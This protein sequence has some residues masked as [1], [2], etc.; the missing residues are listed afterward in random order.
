LN[1]LPHRDLRLTIA[2]LSDQALVSLG[3]FL[4]QVIL[5]RYLSPQDY[6]VFA[7]IF[8]TLILLNVCHWALV[9][10]PLSVIGASSSE[11]RL[12]Q[13]TGS[14][15]LLT[16]LLALP[17]AAIITGVTLFLGRPQLVLWVVLA[18]LTWQLQE[19]LRRGLMAHLLH[20]TAFFGDAISYLG[21]GAIIWGLASHGGLT[22]PGA[23]AVVALT[24]A[25]AAAVQS[26]QLR[27]KFARFRETAALVTVYWRCGR[28]A[29]GAHVTDT[30]TVQAF[31]WALA[32]LHG[33]EQAA[34]FQ[35]AINVLG[36]T[37]P[38]LLGM[39]NLIVPS[40]ARTQDA[41]EVR[42]TWRAT[43]KYATL[44]FLAVAPCLLALLLWPKNVLAVFYGRSSV[45]LDLSGVVQLLALAYL[46]A[47]WFTVISA[48]FNGMKKA[49]FVFGSELFGLAVALL[50]GVALAQHQGVLGAGVGV[51]LVYSAR[52]IG[53]S[54][55]LSRLYRSGHRGRLDAMPASD[56][57]AVSPSSGHDQ[58]PIFDGTFVGEF[59][60]AQ[61]P[62]ERR[63]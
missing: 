40:S 61:K 43:K 24:S 41:G 22:L 52:L 36:I 33:P 14:S 12:R 45:Y 37:N 9:A 10:Y 29:L 39:M 3:G 23:F 44:G 8:G 49:S 47:Y 31:P 4:T 53:A 26:L 16:S 58:V 5:A 42:G 60:L 1:Q 20:H 54:F 46:I 19:T 25:A 21:Q 35:A 11:E 13:L 56:T 2:S 30:G 63:D 57:G 27:L 18:S 55:F 7:L 62:G 32:I 6:G 34:F 15:L 50:L 17:F 48:F 59:K 38:V 28:W 51:L